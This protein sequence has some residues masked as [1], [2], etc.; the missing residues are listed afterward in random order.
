M[1]AR[2]Q[3][4]LGS[5]FHATT[6]SLF[7]AKIDSTLCQIAANDYE[8]PKDCYNSNT[9][10]VSSFET[11]DTCSDNISDI[12]HEDGNKYNREHDESINTDNYSEDAGSMI[13]FPNPNNGLFTIHIGDLNCNYY[14]IVITDISGRCVLSDNNLTST[15]LT[16]DLRKN[17]KGIYLV[18]IYDENGLNIKRQKIIV[19]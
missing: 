17:G 13:F 15:Q 8:S 9:R 7:S 3:I 6:G 11:K 19:K 2:D 12:E 16:I 18:Q 10:D 14:S 1:G 5:G 4:F